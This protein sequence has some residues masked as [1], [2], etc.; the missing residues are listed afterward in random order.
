M[1]GQGGG[2]GL[3]WGIRNV[4]GKGFIVARVYEREGGNNELPVGGNQFPQLKYSP[5]LL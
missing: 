3:F 1:D 2:S 5:F 4:F